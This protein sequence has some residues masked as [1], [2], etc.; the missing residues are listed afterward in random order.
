MF[1]NGAQRIIE[2]AHERPAETLRLHRIAERLLG[3]A[4]A[5]LRCLQLEKQ[6]A[7]LA[8]HHQIGEPRMNTHPDEDRLAFR[9][10]GTGFGHLIGA[11]MDD[12]RAGQGKAQRLHHGALQIGL[13]CATARQRPVLPW[14][15]RW[16]R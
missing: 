9:A 10:A 4:Q 13:G 16:A 2:T 11:V 12:R 6:R 8:K 7:S 15:S 1:G 5:A 14:S 3:G